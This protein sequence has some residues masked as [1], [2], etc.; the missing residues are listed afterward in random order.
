MSDPLRLT[1]LGCGS[2]PGVP[3]V[4]GDWGACDPQE[5]RNRRLR[6]AALVERFGPDGTTTVVIDCGPD[7]RQQMLRAAVS[8]IDAILVTHAHADHIH[9]IDDIRSFS[10]DQKQRIQVHA[11]AETASRLFDAFGYC[12]TKPANSGYDPIAIHVEIFE[13][14]PFS[15][16]GPGGPIEFLPFRQVHGRIHSLGFRIGSLA[17]CS[18]VSDFPDAAVASL[19]G[20]RH[21]VIDALQYKPHRNHLSLDESL[22]W[23]AR[24]GAES[25]TLTHMHTPLDYGVL[26]ER[27]PSHVQPGFDGLRIEFDLD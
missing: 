16:D 7:F 15:V 14:E 26:V 21:L 2:S 18:D 20:V 24:L 8:R 5:P 23:I 27:L 19:Q 6:C 1:I 12:F 3:R 25:A 13:G 11:D 9:G 17:Y 22:D 4:T 10:L